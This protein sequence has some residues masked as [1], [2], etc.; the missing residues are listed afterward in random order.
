MKF[1]AI[2]ALRRKLSRD[3]TALGL[4]VTLESPS[5]TEMAVA[6][7]LDW[8]VIDAEHGHLDWKE[9][10]EHL[11]ATVRSETVALVRLAEL[12][13]G[14]IKR[15]LDIGADGVVIP[16]VE[17]AE[18]VRQAVAWARYPTEGLRGIGAERAT[19]WGQCFVEH[20]AQANDHVLVVPIIES[21]RAASEVPRM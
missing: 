13:G 1:A 18:Q 5:I 20:A 11:R 9:I 19:G 21:V 3:E 4:W 10:V 14:L 2:Q 17:T 6:L 7:G 8:V 12:N 15:A 16:W